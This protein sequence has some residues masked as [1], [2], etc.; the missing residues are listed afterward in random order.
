MTAG[1]RA[2]FFDVGGTLAYPHPSFHG[3]IAHV[4]Q[5]YGLDV[6]AA[7]AE[8][9]EPTV[10][11]RIAER[12][13]AG[14]GY[15]L[16]ATR[17]RAFWVWVYQTF[18]T[19]LGYPDAARTELPGKLFETFIRLE[20]YRLYDDAIPT[21]QRLQPM[22]LIIGVISNWEE[23]LERLMVGLGIREF[24]HFI[25]V[26]GLSG[27]EKPDPEIFARALAAA[28]VRP[29][30]AVHV[31]D[32]LRDDV[33]GAEAVGVRA[34]L[35]DRYG[36]YQAAAQATAEAAGNRSASGGAT[37]KQAAR[38]TGRQATREPSFFLTA[39]PVALSPEAS[40]DSGPTARDSRLVI[41]SLLDLPALLGLEPLR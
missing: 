19:E 6:D 38:E 4:C 3:L 18:L 32:S 16:N 26:S 27:V 15:S 14:R 8:R 35:L 7:D 30:E 40:A 24:F 11:A 41:P 33:E 29:E 34:V 21:L 37:D 13:D 9:A 5:Q 31:G 28:G 25:V 1:I 10:W 2:V 17:S 22:D 39:A 36:R 12:E 23:W 20:N